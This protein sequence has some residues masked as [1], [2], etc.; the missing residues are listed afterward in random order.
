MTIRPLPDSPPRIRAS[1]PADVLGVVPYLLG[2]HPAE[3]VVLVLLSRTTVVLTARTD[4]ASIASTAALVA[5]VEDLADLHGAD[6]V[7]VVAYAAERAP[8]TRLLEGL[9]ARLD[10]V[11]LVDLLHVDGDRWFSLLCRSGCCPP[12][13]T[14][15]DLAGSRTAAEAVWAGLTAWPSRDDLR[16]LAEP[17]TD[18][19]DERRALVDR[20]A[21]RLLP[22][23]PGQLAATLRQVQ[24]LRGAV[25]GE[26]EC[27]ELAVAMFD[28]DVRHGVWL[29]QT[30]ADAPGAVALWSRVVRATVDPFR[31]AP[32]CQLAT[33]GW[34]SGD[35]ALMSV[36]LEALAE[37]DPGARLVR[38]LD[39]INRLALPPSWW[40]E[41]P[42]STG[43]G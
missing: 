32:L 6:S 29:A 17:P 38:T 27:A 37:V 8:V 31:T 34:L 43:R 40:D 15:Y 30:R 2:F 33:A 4:L 28:V 16:R 12:E 5:M 41:P 11:R 7:V 26:E 1:R 3:D 10:G 42:G 39:M 19:L 23:A 22:V 36:C 25:P 21:E 20:V 14:P 13:G 9:P 18:R 35:G 24:R